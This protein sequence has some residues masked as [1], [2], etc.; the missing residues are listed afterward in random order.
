MYLQKSTGRQLQFFT[1][2]ELQKSTGK[3]L[4][5]ESLPV[6]F[7]SFAHDSMTSLDDESSGDVISYICLI[8][9]IISQVMT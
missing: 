8:Y 7:C 4:L 6:D 5:L 2:L 9:D 1:R 3:L